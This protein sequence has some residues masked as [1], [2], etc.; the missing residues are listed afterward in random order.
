MPSSHYVKWADLEKATDTS[1]SSNNGTDPRLDRV[2]EIA[3]VCVEDRIRLRREFG[4]TTLHELVILQ[5]DD[6]KEMICTDYGDGSRTLL[7]RSR[8]QIIIDCIWHD[9]LEDPCEI[10]F[11]EVLQA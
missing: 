11:P 3:G 7:A 2:L 6:L 4:I 10:S 8:L 5:P 1:K 9:A